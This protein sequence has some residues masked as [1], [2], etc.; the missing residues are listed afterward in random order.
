MGFYVA[1][2]GASN[3]NGSINNP[4][5][6]QSALDYPSGVKPGDTIWIRGGTYGDGGSTIFNSKLVGEAGKPITVRAFPG[7]QVVID[8]SIMVYREYTTFW[9]LEV[10]NSDLKRST[11]I[12]GSYPGDISRSDGFNVLASNTKFINNIVHDQGEGFGFWKQAVNAELY[13]N[14]VYNNGWQGPDRGHGYSIYAQN[15]V[16]TKLIPDNITFNNFG[17]YGVHVYGESIQLLGF[18]FEGNVKL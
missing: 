15:E 5:D 7:E 6:L 1:P 13:G 11:A 14:I 8:G 12:A 3:G 17:Q 16:G 9:G 10:L 4:W 2:D 18:R